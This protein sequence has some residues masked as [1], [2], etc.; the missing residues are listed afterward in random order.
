MAIA[1]RIP[2]GGV[3][4][5]VIPLIAL[6]I[7]Y[8]YELYLADACLDRGGS[9]NYEDWSCSVSE[10]FAYSPYLERHWGKTLVAL[11]FSIS[12]LIV[13]AINRFKK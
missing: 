9:F 7:H 8:G 11:S 2:P 13:I 12:G 3:F 1:T 10:R 5:L 4:L 6:G